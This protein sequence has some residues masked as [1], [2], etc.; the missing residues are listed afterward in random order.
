MLGAA[1]SRPSH[2]RRDQRLGIPS[3]SSSGVEPWR[4]RRP[5]TL[6]RSIEN[7]WNLRPRGSMRTVS[8]SSLSAEY[9][10]RILQM[11]VRRL[12]HIGHRLLRCVRCVEVGRALGGLVAHEAS[13]SSRTPCCAA[14]CRGRSVARGLPP[15]IFKD[16]LR[17]RPLIRKNLSTHSTKCRVCAATKLNRPVA[18]ER[19]EILN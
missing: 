9:T 14:D 12:P 13:S 16:S 1:A 3:N 5:S 4:W 15:E 2:R 19:S 6:R 10:G 17:A 7:R 11:P 8:S 18:P